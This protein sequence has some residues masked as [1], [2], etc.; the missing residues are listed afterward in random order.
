MRSVIVCAYRV[1]QPLYDAAGSRDMVT[2]C[3]TC[4]CASTMR[5]VLD[6]GMISQ[7]VLCVYKDVVYVQWSVFVGGHIFYFSHR[8][9]FCTLM[10]ERVFLEGG[11]IFK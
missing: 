11:G 8:R 9:H 2:G 1:V 7:E 6:V 10:G 3:I 5:W 4:C